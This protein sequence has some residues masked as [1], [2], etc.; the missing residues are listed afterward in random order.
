MPIG[1]GTHQHDL[2]V[3]LLEHRPNI[4]SGQWFMLY[5]IVSHCIF[6]S[7]NVMIV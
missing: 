7:V 6:G 3:E 5:L 2:P 1:S 4:R